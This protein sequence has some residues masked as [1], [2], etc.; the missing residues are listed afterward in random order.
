MGHCQSFQRW[1]IMFNLSRL[2]SRHPARPLLA[3]I[4]TQTAAVVV[5]QRRYTP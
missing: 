5:E 4:G 3:A 1:W 2:R